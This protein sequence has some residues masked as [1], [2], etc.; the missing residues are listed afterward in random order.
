MKTMAMFNVDVYEKSMHELRM[1]MDSADFDALIIPHEDEF[2][3]EHVPED[4]ERLAF[5]TGFTGSAGCC[6]VFRNKEQA[7]TT[8]FVDGRYTIQAQRQVP[9]DIAIASYKDSLSAVRFAASKIKPGQRVGIDPKVHSAKWAKDAKSILTNA[10][11][12][13]AFA[14]KNPIDQLWRNKPE[15]KNHPFMAFPDRYAGMSSEKKRELIAVKIGDLGLDAALLCDAESVNWLLNI[16]GHDIPYLP[17]VRCC[18][19]IYANRSVEVFLDGGTERCEKMSDVCGGSV[20]VFSLKALDAALDRIGEG[21]L[22]IGIDPTMT[23]A[24]CLSMLEKSGAAV[25]QTAD[26]CA[27]HKAIKTSTEVD[28]FRAAHLKD[29]VAMC[30]FL[31]WLDRKAAEHADADEATIAEQAASYRSNQENFIELS[32]ATISAL[33]SN[34]AMCHYCHENEEHP[35]QLGKDSIYLIDSGAHYYDGTTD[36]TRTV[37]VGEPTDEMKNMFTR[38]LRGNIALASACFPK[39]TKGSQLDIL[40][41]MPLWEVGSDYAHG[42]GH[43]VGHC[44]SV[45]EGPHRISP[46]SVPNE[47]QLME[48]MIVTD[49]PGFYKEGEYGIR[50]ENELLVTS[51]PSLSGMLGFET[52]TL[53]PFDLRLVNPELMS[54]AEISWLNSYH[55]GVRHAIMPFLSDQEIS[56]LIAATRQIEKEK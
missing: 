20:A 34:A 47:T 51:H 52:L 27:L 13:L 11:A 6:V 45:H 3:G 50:C 33:G 30:K 22:K 49:E 19:I 53:V 32:F 42:T 2:L 35:R 40:A 17:I 23:S 56:W 12:E 1:I 15:P 43:G 26:P 16:R 36:I 18:A 7:E 46:R 39:G 44:L 54:D 10:D 14:A 37:A 5:I 55:A 48:N 29:G 31:A 24:H 8:L 41:R 4:K 38:V 9:E 28:G 21:K 25:I